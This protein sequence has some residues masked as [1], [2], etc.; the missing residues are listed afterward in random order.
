MDAPN[1]Q[2]SPVVHLVGPAAMAAPADYPSPTGA[3]VY[4]LIT[5][6]GRPVRPPRMSQPHMA[7]P[8]LFGAA[9]SDP[10]RAALDSVFAAVVTYGEDYPALLRE[11]RSACQE[12]PRT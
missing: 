12:H 1:P 2:P 10:L 4:A 8:A 3:T 7:V 5:T 9:G 6:V 11:I